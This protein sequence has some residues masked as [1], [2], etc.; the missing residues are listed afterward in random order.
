M[1]APAADDWTGL[2]EGPLPVD[3]IHR[4]A[5]RPDCGAVTLFLGTVR[6]HAE[7]RSGV[8]H[9]DYEAYAEQVV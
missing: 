2:T 1:R 6:D 3:A 9:L 8:L 5:V 4:W 7:G